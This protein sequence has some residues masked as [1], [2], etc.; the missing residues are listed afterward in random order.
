MSS[1]NITVRIDEELA[2][3]AKVF[4][5]R[6][7]TS[8]SRLVSQ[9]LERLVKRNHAYDLAKKRALRRLRGSQELGWTKPAARDDLHGR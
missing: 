4:A 1:T 5:A 6:R 7:G 3:A 8:L 9:E 2:Q